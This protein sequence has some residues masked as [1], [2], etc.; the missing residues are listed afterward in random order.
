MPATTPLGIVYPCSGDTIDC[1]VFEDNANSIQDALDTV[2][3]LV[4]QALGPPA[5]WVRTDTA[6]QTI[7]AGVTAVMAY[8]VIMYDTASMFNIGTPTIITIP[9]DG[10]YLAHVLPTRQSLATSES[11][12]RAAI[13]VNGAERAFQKNDLGTGTFSGTPQF[14]VSALLPALVAGDQVTSTHLFTGVGSQQMRHALAV[15]KVANI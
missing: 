5:V 1:S 6:G 11:S 14:L 7:N 10:T 9:E 8:G 12:H 4:D 13:L 3:N 15:T 2:Q